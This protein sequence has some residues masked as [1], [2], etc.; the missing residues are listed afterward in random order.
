MYTDLL[1][2]VS[3]QLE[4]D[5]LKL[6]GLPDIAMQVQRAVADPMMTLPKLAQIIGK[7]PALSARIVKIANSAWMG[8]PVRAENLPQAVMRLGFWQIRNVALGMALEGLYESTDPMVKQELAAN[9]QQSM[10]LTAAAVTLLNHYPGETDLHSHTLALACTCSRIGILPLLAVSEQD[11]F[12]DIE[13]FRA[14]KQALAVPL[15]VKILTHWQFSD[16]IVSLHKSWREGIGSMRPAYLSFMQLAGILTGQIKVSEP[17][18]VLKM[19]AEHG[20]I[21]R[22]GVWHQPGVQADYKSI[23]SA[24]RD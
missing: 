9:W 11:S 1:N 14:A 17:G 16:E 24:L 20:C 2:Q 4:T 19:Y 7:D 18:E 23:L 21:N 22:P 3:T 12:N 6:P 13:D 8:R 15:G 10:T 5:S